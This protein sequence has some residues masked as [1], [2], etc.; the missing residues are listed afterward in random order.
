L[1]GKYDHESDTFKSVAEAR[2][3]YTAAVKAFEAAKYQGSKTW[4][5]TTAAD[6]VLRAATAFYVQIEAY[7]E[8]K[9]HEITKEHIW[10]MQ[11]AFDDIR[12]RLSN[13]IKDVESYNYYRGDFWPSVIGG[14]FMSKFPPRL[15]YY[16]GSVDRMDI[17]KLNPLV[18]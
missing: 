9:A 18:K 3:A 8:L 1:S 7:P 12:K 4:E 10:N 5:L 17:N 6:K 11:N 2:S 15:D 14:Y 16:K 13:W